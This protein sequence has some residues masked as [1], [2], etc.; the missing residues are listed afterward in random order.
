VRAVFHLIHEDPEC[1]RLADRTP[2]VDWKTVTQFLRFDLLRNMALTMASRHFSALWAENMADMFNRA[3]NDAS[4][5]IHQDPSELCVKLNPHRTRFYPQKFLT[6][7]SLLPGKSPYEVYIPTFYTH[8]FFSATEPLFITPP[9]FFE[10]YR[11]VIANVPRLIPICEQ[12]QTLLTQTDVSRV[13]AGLRLIVD[14]Y[15]PEVTVAQKPKRKPV[16]K[17]LTD[18][19]ERKSLDQRGRK[20]SVEP[21]VRSQVLLISDGREIADDDE[22]HVQL[23]H[24][25]RRKTRPIAPSS[26]VRGKTLERI[27]E[28]KTAPPKKRRGDAPKEERR[29]RK[30]FKSSDESTQHL[31]DDVTVDARFRN[32]L[33]AAWSNFRRG[34]WTPEFMKRIDFVR[35]R[36][37]FYIY[38][39]NALAYYPP[40]GH[41]PHARVMFGT[42]DDDAAPKHD[43]ASP[44]YYTPYRLHLL[45]A[46][47]AKFDLP[48]DERKAVAGRH[49]IALVRC[50]DTLGERQEFLLR[51]ASCYPID[52]ERGSSRHWVYRCLRP[53]EPP[54]SDLAVGA[55]QHLFNY[56]NE[57]WKSTYS[58]FVGWSCVL[59]REE[60]I[61]CATLG[62]MPDGTTI[63]QFAAALVKSFEDAYDEN[64][65][66]VRASVHVRPVGQEYP[67]Q[68]VLE[69]WD[70]CTPVWSLADDSFWYD[71]LFFGDSNCSQ[72]LDMQTD[73]ADALDSLVA[74]VHRCVLNRLASPVPEHEP[75]LAAANVYAR[76]QVGSAF[77]LATHFVLIAIQRIWGPHLRHLAFHCPVQRILMPG[78]VTWNQYHQ[79]N[80]AHLP[81]QVDDL[82]ASV[83][84]LMRRHISA[85]S[86]RGGRLRQQLMAMAPDAAPLDPRMLCLFQFFLR[87]TK[88][89]APDFQPVR[90]H[91]ERLVRPSFAAEMAATGHSE[92]M[93]QATRLLGIRLDMD[94][95]DKASINDV[96]DMLIRD[97]ARTDERRDTKNVL[98]DFNRILTA[99]VGNDPSRRT[100]AVLCATRMTADDPILKHLAALRVST[101]LVPSATL[102]APSVRPQFPG[103]MPRQMNGKTP[104]FH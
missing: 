42:S 97:P 52:L 73:P 2:S 51:S 102:A 77:D 45:M 21:N 89:L 71:T 98:L 8:H 31:P 81:E 30:V 59:V 44:L 95:L 23:V 70:R 74:Y 96:V 67:L 33:R 9:G 60:D 82:V 62:C 79:A 15:A 103:L 47:G 99:A 38:G 26:T 92:V 84:N 66:I 36:Y 101:P 78:R 27:L 58:L 20:R 75:K 69:R 24:K 64:L 7:P 88:E 90:A 18:G 104:L 65:A 35:L 13:H 10:V 41:L 16:Q 48:L 1:C 50:F 46:R 55:A 11:D 37:S 28:T 49:R 3:M 53:T 63:P 19:S 29:P 83:K 5:G 85:R 93:V 72:P 56:G 25:K 22:E 87:S 17:L 54:L 14:N 43:E 6:M 91:V 12:V 94:T 61:L 68:A 32:G 80:K 39:S 100:R 57:G 40:W 86:K 4:A 34:K 76:N